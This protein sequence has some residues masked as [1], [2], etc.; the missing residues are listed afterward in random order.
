MLAW[1]LTCDTQAS[2]GSAGILLTTPS[3]CQVPYLYNILAFF[4]DSVSACH[5]EKAVY[6]EQNY[7]ED[8]NSILSPFFISSRAGYGILHPLVFVRLFPTLIN[9]YVLHHEEEDRRYL[10][11]LDLL[12]QMNV[13]RLAQFIKFPRCEDGVCV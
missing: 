9:L 12:Q 4:A 5:S 1:C 13:D 10:K 6:A 3:A 7:S 2:S 8:K 11:G